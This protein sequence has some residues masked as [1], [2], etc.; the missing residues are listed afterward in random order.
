VS[1]P[2]PAIGRPNGRTNVR[3]GHC[4]AVA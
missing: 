4:Q 1:H 2:S 3:A